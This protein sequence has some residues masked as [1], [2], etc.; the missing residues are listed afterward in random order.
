MPASLPDPWL[1]LGVLPEDEQKQLERTYGSKLTV[2]DLSDEDVTRDDAGGIYP[3]SKRA[4]LVMGAQWRRV[5]NVDTDLEVLIRLQ[6][7]EP[8]SRIQR[9]SAAVFPFQVDRDLMAGDLRS[10]PLPAIA[11][12]FSEAQQRSVANIMIALAVGPE[13]N[14]IDPLAKLP[15]ASANDHFA[16][17]VALQYWALH[18]EGEV[19]IPKR[20]AKINGTGVS[21]VQR[22]LTRARKR[23]MVPQHAKS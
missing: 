22:W 6:V 10:V 19:A 17:L 5:R 2:D 1:D 20:M 11:A 21:T 14:A 3:R 18:D 4:M 16:G 9:A 8:E 13:A 12:A 23:G 15:K 7:D